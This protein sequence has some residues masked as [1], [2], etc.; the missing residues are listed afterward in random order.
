MIDRRGIQHRWAADGSKRDE[1]GRRV[2]A[3]SEARAA[4]RG[5]LAAV[6]EITGLARS[7]IGRG[8]KEL[9]TPSL[10]R[11]R[12]RRE[13]GG[14]RP[15]TDYLP[16]VF[17]EEMTEYL[18]FFRAGLP[19]FASTFNVAGSFDSDDVRD[20]YRSPVELGW[21]KTINLNHDFLG[22]EALEAEKANPRRTI[23]TL[24]WNPDDVLD[25]HASLFRQ[26]RPYQFMEMPRD[27][28]GFV[29]ADRVLI[30]GRDVGVA[31]S[32]GYSYY[33]PEMLSLCVIDVADAEIGTDV[34]VIWGAPG[35]PQKEIRAKVAPAP[36]KQDNRRVD[37]HSLR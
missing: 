5:G 28:R 21:S 19:A 23:R 33:F 12:V 17:D 35:E 8:L 4:G 34:T 10:P 16:A 22:R 15:L 24:V 36:Y 6:S 30:D 25:V 1:R 26:G 20:W 14:P 27:Q 31:T 11:G 7:T 13:G 2:F 32:R 18:E 37:L 3:A 9:D 29:W